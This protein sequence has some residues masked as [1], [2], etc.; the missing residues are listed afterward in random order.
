MNLHR[1]RH[2]DHDPKQAQ[3]SWRPRPA[4][5]LPTAEYRPGMRFLWAALAVAPF[6]AVVAG[7]L[8]GRIRARSCCALPAEQ[9]AR[10]VPAEDPGPAQ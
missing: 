3:Q 6:V 1:S 10:L 7:M 9:D 5:T 2:Q 8:T 4:A